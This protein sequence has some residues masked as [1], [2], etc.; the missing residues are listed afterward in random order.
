M[1]FFTFQ[2]KITFLN[3]KIWSKFNTGKFHSI[4]QQSGQLIKHILKVILHENV[5][6][7]YSAFYRNTL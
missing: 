7:N 1:K 5:A 2:F 6:K 3:V 4:I